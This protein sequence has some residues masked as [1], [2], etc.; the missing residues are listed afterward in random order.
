MGLCYFDDTIETWQ[1]MHISHHNT[2]STAITNRE[3]ENNAPPP[4]INICTDIYR[5]WIK[6]FLPGQQFI[7]HNQIWNARCNIY[8][9]MYRQCNESMYKVASPIC[10]TNKPEEFPRY[11]LFTFF[12]K[13]VIN[14]VLKPVNFSY[15]SFPHFVRSLIHKLPPTHNH[16]SYRYD[17]STVLCVL[18]IAIPSTN[19]YK[20]HKSES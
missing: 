4:F 20:S 12:P 15:S 7:R 5:L 8:D 2:I 11:T 16:S 13:L 9:Y 10:R 3:S 14:V 19:L 6:K 17:I 1:Y 18:F